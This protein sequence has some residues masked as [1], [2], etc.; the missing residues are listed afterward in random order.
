MS[1]T[2]IQWLAIVLAAITPILVVFGAGLL[3]PSFKNN[4]KP[5]KD[6]VIQPPNWIFSVVWT[7]LTLAL[8][9]VTA[10]F[11]YQMNNDVPAQFCLVAVYSCIL[12]TWVCWMALYPVSHKLGFVSLLVS[13][14]FSVSFLII[15]SLYGKLYVWAFFPVCIWLA[16]A[17]SINAVSIENDLKPEIPS[18]SPP[19]IIF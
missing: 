18:A 10:V 13:I 8:G 9:I 14:A 4:T 17:A 1:R 15:L 6:P 19:V 16:Y 12:I 2:I 7:Y 11:L 5:S 3:L